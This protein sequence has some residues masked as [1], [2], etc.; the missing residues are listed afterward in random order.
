[1]CDVYS[2]EALRIVPYNMETYFALLLY[3]IILAKRKF[4][5]DG[6]VLPGGAGVLLVCSCFLGFVNF[7]FP[8]PVFVILMSKE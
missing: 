7:K 6:E 2:L 4:K 3:L 5:V 8:S 1:M